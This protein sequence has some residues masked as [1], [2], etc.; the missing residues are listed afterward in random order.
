IVAAGSGSRM[1]SATPKQFLPIAGKPILYYTLQAFFQAFEDMQIIL[2]LP[3]AYLAFGQKLKEELPERSRIQLT[4][5]GT[6]RFKSVQ[7][8]LAFIKQTAIVFVHDGVRCLITPT[9]IRRCYT[10]ALDSGSAIPAIAA[11]DSLRTLNESGNQLLDRTKVRIIQTPQTFRSDI[12]KK[13]FAQ[14][15]Q[16]IFTDEAS[17]VEADGE[18]VALIEGE[19]DNLKITRAIDLRL[20]EILL[21]ERGHLNATK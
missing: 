1:G 14:P 2:V 20:A 18:S 8:G 4:S 11:T 16:E 3:E 13:A 15:Y 7:N 12:L 5:G 21:E 17:V 10:Q 19:T 6:T 9:L